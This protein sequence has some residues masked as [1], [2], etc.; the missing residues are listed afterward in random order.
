MIYIK[1]HN[2]LFNS[3]RV[4]EPEFDTSIQFEDL[5]ALQLAK[6]DF[7]QDLNDYQEWLSSK[8]EVIGD[9][10]WV[11]GQEVKEGVDFKIVYQYSKKVVSNWTH[12]IDTP[13]AIPIK[14]SKDDVAMSLITKLTPLNNK[15]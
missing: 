9:N 6:S 10:S 3:P 12:H 11:D 4:E 15:P 1:E 7:S 5:D 2:A 14:E 8:I 13:V